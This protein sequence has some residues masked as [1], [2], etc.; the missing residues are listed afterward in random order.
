MLTR[1]GID[2]RTVTGDNLATDIAIAK[3]TGILRENLQCDQNS[4]AL[5]KRAMECKVFMRMVHDYS[6]PGDAT[7]NQEKFDADSPYLQVLARSSP[8]DK[9]TLA[10]EKCRKL[11]VLENID[12][13]PDKQVVAM[14]G[15]GT[16]N[17]P[18][19]R[20][21]NVDFARH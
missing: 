20:N 7:L 11:K 21:A 3:R 10:K 16:N 18:A 2:V 12:V 6:N 8:D 19:L 5:P 17:A 13:F 4:K 9:L 14:T 15:D 1:T